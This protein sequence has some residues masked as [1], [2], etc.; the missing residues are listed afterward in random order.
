MKAPRRNVMRAVLEDIYNFQEEVQLP[1]SAS[2]LWEDEHLLPA[3]AISA[4]LLHGVQGLLS[5]VWVCPMDQQGLCVPVLIFMWRLLFGRAASEKKF[6]PF[7]SLKGSQARQRI[8]LL[9]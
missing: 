6:I 1:I 2:A 9:T 3:L 7:S 5:R 8:F 4:P